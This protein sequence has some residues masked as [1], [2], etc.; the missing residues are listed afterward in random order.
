M[1][2]NP[3][4]LDWEEGSVIRKSQVQQIFQILADFGQLNKWGVVLRFAL[5]QSGVWLVWNSLIQQILKHWF[6]AQYKTCM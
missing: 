5:D 4:S 2:Q 6:R 3:R 1:F